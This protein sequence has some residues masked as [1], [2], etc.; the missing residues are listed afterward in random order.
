MSQAFDP[1]VL[2]V[3]L[4]DYNPNKFVRATLEADGVVLTLRPNIPHRQDGK[5]TLYQPT[6]YFFPENTNH[7]SITYEIFDD[8]SFTTRSVRH[9]PA[10]EHYT[11]DNPISGT[12]PELI[13]KL[14]QII[15]IVTSHDLNSQII[16]IVQDEITLIGEVV[17]EDVI[18]QVFDN[19]TLVGI[20]IEEDAIQGSLF[21]DDDLT[22][23]I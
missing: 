16:G 6:V 2:D 10:N 5:Y 12:N 23:I 20:V 18:G 1:I 3:V 11:L 17:I 8:S 19:V 9:A 15:D 4:W 22:G 7:L 21:A 14:N 13:N